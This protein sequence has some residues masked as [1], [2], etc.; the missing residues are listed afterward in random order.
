[1]QQQR[2]ASLRTPPIG[3]AHRGA[4][5][6]A[7]DNTLP[8]FSLAL[9][10]GATGLETDVVRTKDGVVVLDHDGRIRG[11]LR[12]IPIASLNRTELPPHIP[13][14]DD[15]YETCGTAYEL[16][17]DVKDPDAIAPLV[18]AARRH[19]AEARLWI[20][21]P[22]LDL[23]SSWRDR[24][25]ARLVCSTRLNSLKEGPERRA[26]LLSDR[27]I[28]AINMH[29]SDWSGGLTTLFHRFGRFCLAWDAQHE[30]VI[31]DLV[32]MGID[33]IFCDHVD[34]LMTSISSDS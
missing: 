22:D 20:C 6:H 25:S 14:I 13:S 18:V 16:S 15:L 7:D 2:I 32:R 9:S 5:A 10:L 3:F 8:S 28:D 33:G 1:M 34:R 19:D 24:T 29:H 30:R 31:A 12:S 21:H 11:R 23:L 27:G 4:R 26:A 17:V